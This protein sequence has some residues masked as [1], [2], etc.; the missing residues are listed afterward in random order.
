MPRKKKQPAPPI[1][2]T[3][4]N[5]AGRVDVL[6]LQFLYKFATAK[7]PELVPVMEHNKGVI[8]ATLNERLGPH[9]IPVELAEQVRPFVPVLSLIAGE[10]VRRMQ[11]AQQQP[12]E[13]AA[14]PSDEH[15]TEG[16][17]AA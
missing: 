9:I 13:T 6:A 12:N 8:H 10:V 2:L 3:T 5:P 7:L 14:R 17:K 1:D 16:G 4:V 11:Q 15:T